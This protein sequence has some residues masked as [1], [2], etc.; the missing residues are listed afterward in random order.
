MCGIAGYF[1]AKVEEKDLTQ[2]FI[3]SIKHRGPDDDGSYSYKNCTII[4]TRLSII[5]LASGKQPMFSDDGNISVVQ[6]GEIYN[7]IELREELIGFGYHFRTNSDTEVLLAL[8]QKFGKT[9]VNKLNGMFAIAIIDRLENKLFIYRDRLGVK[10]LYIYNKNGTFL[11]SSEIKTFLKYPNFDSEINKQS[12]HNYLIYNYVPIPDTIFK[13]VKHLNPGS[14]VEISLDDNTVSYTKYWSLE[15]SKEIEV[16]NENELIDEISDL[17]LDATKV[18]LRSDVPVGAF[19]SGGLDSS[20]ICAY[21]NQITKSSFDTFTIGFHEKEFDESEYANYINDKYS[22]IKNI[23]FLDADII[24]LWNKTTWHN[25]QPHGDISFIPT[26]I[27]SDFTS[28]KYKVVLTGDGGDELFAGYTK[29]LT[30]MTNNINDVE[31]FNSISLFKIDSNFKELYD[32]NFYNEINIRQPLELFLETIKQVDLK[33][34]VNKA[35]FFDVA[36]L[37]PGNNL[38]KPDK[39]AMANGLE[40]RSPFLDFRFYELMFKVPGDFKLRNNDTKYIL[41]KLALKHF[42]QEHV[43]RKKQMFTVPIGEWFKNKLS[44]YLIDIVTSER[45]KSRGIFNNNYVLDMCKKHI[46][47]EANFTRELRAIVNLELWFR[48]FIDNN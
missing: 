46:S 29:Y 35:L 34:D 43:Y 42:K 33:D 20:L 23:K 4:N 41:K 28:N 25:D 38:V 30:L 13:N 32:N 21:M 31:Y 17:L 8:Y 9:F 5:D 15:N 2:K 19:L 6:N 3:D 10:P 26:Y 44:T 48:S 24:E 16:K 7:Y 27:L 47:G 37:L 11:F 1:N 40:T 12:I 14:F 36:Q 39:M 18:R 45:F 22:L